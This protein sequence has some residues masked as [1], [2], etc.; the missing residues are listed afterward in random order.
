MRNDLDFYAGGLGNTIRQNAFGKL[1]YGPNLLGTATGNYA[2]FEP[3]I[4]QLLKIPLETL[5]KVLEH[6]GTSR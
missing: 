3:A 2:S 5:A 6:R 4:N 1:L